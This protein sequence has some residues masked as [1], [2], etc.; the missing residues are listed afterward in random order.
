MI[1]NVR[2]L[3]QRVVT[4]AWFFSLNDS[5]YKS[6]QLQ[7]MNKTENFYTVKSQIVDAA[8]ILFF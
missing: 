2:T 1:E 6:K 4:I 5:H 3:F 8:T 7:D